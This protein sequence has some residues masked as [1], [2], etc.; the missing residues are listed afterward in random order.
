FDVIYQAISKMESQLVARIIR[1]VHRYASDAAIIFSVLHGFRLFFMGRFRGP[2]WLAWTTGVLMVAVLVLDGITGYWLIWDQRAQLIISSV[3]SWLGRIFGTSADFVADIQSAWAN[4]TS[5]IW[6]GLLLL[7]HILLFVIVA[8]GYWLHV[9]RLSRPKFLPARHWLIGISL[10]VIVVSAAAPLGMLPPA[11][12]RQLPGPVSLDPLYLFF[13]P[14]EINGTANGLWLIVLALAAAASIF[15]WLPLRRKSTPPVHIDKD[16][17]IGCTKCALD[18]PYQ[19]I[20]MAP[21]TDGKIH[22]FVAH[23][24]LDRCVSCGV[25][26]GSCD[27]Q[28]ISIGPLSRPALWTI[29]DRRVAAARE[30]VPTGK[31]MVAFTCE[32][33]AD[34][35]ARPYLNPSGLSAPDK[36]L[37]VITLPCVA[38]APPDLVSHAL[39][40]GASEA[41]IIGCPPGD[42]AR[43]EG[44]AWTEG[45]LTRTRLPRLR[46]N[47]ANAPIGLY[48]LPPDDF[49][50]GLRAPLTPGRMASPVRWRNLIPALMLVALLYAASVA[51]NWAP[52]VPYADGQARVQI[53]LPSPADL[54][55]A[56]SDERTID[57]TQAAAPVRLILKAD[58]RTLFE[59]TYTLADLTSDRT[60]SLFEDIKLAPGKYHIRFQFESDAVLSR[61]VRVYDRTI[62]LEAV[63]ILL[64]DYVAGAARDDRHRP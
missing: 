64:L 63:E 54:F 39:D 27:V 62:T 53:V 50:Q 2:R 18:C 28:A 9:K 36:A 19:A 10:L 49:A 52:Y 38:S 48:W 43:R 31:V 26:V 11:N 1:A 56:R 15:P 8:V 22:K 47:Y 35:G 51:L 7:V 58:D 46:R 33:H 60:A 6:I 17:C 25:C 12:F 20:T 57:G 42:C 34:H 55:E 13:V 4:D 23:E 16:L 24:N 29:V 59:Q 61:S 41:R 37:E 5:W 40:L 45:R 30:R 14:L 44:N 32:R 3:T 21:R